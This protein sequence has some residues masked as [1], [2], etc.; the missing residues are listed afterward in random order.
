LLFLRNQHIA[1]QAWNPTIVRR[2]LLSIVPLS[3]GRELLDDD[4]RIR[5]GVVADASRVPPLELGG[6][7]ESLLEREHDGDM[8]DEPSGVSR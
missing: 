7:G 1:R 8:D 5:R 4:H 3:A 6:L 2:L